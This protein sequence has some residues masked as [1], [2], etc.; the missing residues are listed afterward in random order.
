MKE[1]QH[2][3]DESVPFK[4]RRCILELLYDM[5]K[6]VPLAQVEL[7]HIEESCETDAQELNWNMVYLEKC[8][9]IEINKAADCVTHVGFTAAITAAGVDLVENRSDFENRFPT[10]DRC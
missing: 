8:G 10:E 4:L 1:T 2:K 3:P 5:F 9:Y 7:S 6:D